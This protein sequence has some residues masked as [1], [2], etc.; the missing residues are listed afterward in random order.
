MK[1]IIVMIAMI[2]LGVVLAGFVM[3]FG[4]AADTLTSAAKA[5]IT[6]EKIIGD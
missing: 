1:Q 2:A 5:E 4:D 3:G 6:Y